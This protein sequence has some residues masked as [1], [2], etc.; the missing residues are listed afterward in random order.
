MFLT[1][2]CDV[3]IMQKDSMILDL[4]KSPASVHDV[5]DLPYLYA[6]TVNG[7]FNDSS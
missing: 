5:V 2:R 4:Y 6:D 3:A 7:R 1:E